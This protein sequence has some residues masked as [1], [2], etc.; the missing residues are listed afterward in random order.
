MA[1]ESSAAAL[2]VPR[3]FELRAKDGGVWSDECQ[4]FTRENRGWQRLAFQLGQR[5]FVVK[6]V[7]VA[8][9]SGHEQV[10]DVFGFSGKVRGAGFKHD[11]VMPAVAPRAWGRNASV[12]SEARATLP[13]PKP[14]SLRNQRRELRRGGQQ[15]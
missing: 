9:R 2:P 15:A 6:Q 7:E 11:A 10:N 13:S 3:K 12:S 8:G 1:S 14:H 4:T 5:R